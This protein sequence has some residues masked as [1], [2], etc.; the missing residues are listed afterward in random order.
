MIF[1]SLVTKKNDWNVWQERKLAVTTKAVI[2]FKGTVMRRYIRHDIING[3]TQNL[4]DPEE[5]ILHV[6]NEY[7]YL[8]KSKK[9]IE[10]FECL[11]TQY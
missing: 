9:I 1:S 4:D 10:L 7:D 2:T 3:L 8:L 5:F 6:K 11:K